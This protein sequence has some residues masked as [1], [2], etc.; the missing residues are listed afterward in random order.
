[1]LPLFLL[2]LLLPPQDIKEAGDSDEELEALLAGPVAGGGPDGAGAA[3]A[4]GGP[5]EVRQELLGSLL[6]QLL[7]RPCHNCGARACNCMH[8]S[9]ACGRSVLFAALLCAAANLLTRSSTWSVMAMTTM[10]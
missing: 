6:V 8:S 10:M 7:L 2:L 5:A 9:R 3:A 1:M 4:A